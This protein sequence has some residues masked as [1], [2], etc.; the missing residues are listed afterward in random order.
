[1]SLRP[2]FVTHLYQATLAQEAGF[3]GFRDEL[4]AACRDLAA[5]DEAGRTWCRVRGYG[6]YTSYASIADLAASAEVFAQLKARLDAHADA[7]RAGL[8]LDLE[9]LRLELSGFWVNILPPGEGH[10]SHLH[11]YNVL[12]G[13]FYVASPPGADTLKLED[14]RLPLMMSAP[15]RTADAAEFVQPF[16]HV[17]VAPGTVLFWESWLRHEV[18]PNRAA[19]PRISV[20]FNYRCV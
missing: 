14:P 4:E 10:S 3:E 8:G 5:G 18:P 12:S 20:S 17:Q 9:G 13:A 19:T 6:G 16:V 7:C 15:A 1:M 2:L 11:P